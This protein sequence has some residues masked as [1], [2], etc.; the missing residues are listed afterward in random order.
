MIIPLP[1]FAEQYRI[2]QKLE[3][4]MQTC[5]ELEGSIKQSASY[6][7]KLLQQVL[8]EALRKEV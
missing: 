4:L 7:E 2:V 8:M 3:K 6:N 5:D 1:P